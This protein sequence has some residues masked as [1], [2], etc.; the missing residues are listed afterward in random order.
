ML[1]VLTQED[2][3]EVL[4]K[5][6]KL[7]VRI[8]TL[9]R[10]IQDLKEQKPQSLD[11]SDIIEENASIIYD[12]SIPADQYVFGRLQNEIP[13]LNPDT[14]NKW[15]NKK[16]P[17]ILKNIFFRYASDEDELMLKELMNKYNLHGHKYR[18]NI[19]MRRSEEFRRIF[20]E[21][22]NRFILEH[23]NRI[24]E[25]QQIESTSTLVIDTQT[26][27]IQFQNR[28]NEYIH[29]IKEFIHDN[30]KDC[31]IDVYHEISLLLKRVYSNL[32]KT[33]GWVPEQTEKEFIRVFDRR[34]ES[35]IE[36]LSQDAVFGT[37]F[38]NLLDDEI[39]S[40]ISENTTCETD[41]QSSE[42]YS[43][44]YSDDCPM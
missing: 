32:K 44:V 18:L 27:D 13:D 25:D 4:S 36:M 35:S 17:W 15:R 28:Y 21:Y 38:L 20:I 16:V 3:A 19:L 11:T 24:E 1:S 31:S 26:V 34:P 40:Y 23:N 8:S 7:T 9:E 2:L 42:D 12:A 14:L 41:D 33:Y 5:I 37:I 39:D 22:L 30:N 10:E 6:E 29:K 43:T